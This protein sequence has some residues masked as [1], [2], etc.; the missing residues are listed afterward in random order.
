LE[1]EQ[2]HIE[3]LHGDAGTQGQAK[4]KAKYLENPPGAPGWKH[5]VTVA[6]Y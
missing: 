3:D 5:T 6:I 4:R 2:E 1:E